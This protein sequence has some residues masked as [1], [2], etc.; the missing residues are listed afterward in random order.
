[1]TTEQA[2]NGFGRLSDTTSPYN[3]MAF[4]V[5]SI[6][7]GMA[8]NTLV[9]VKAV[10]ATATGFEVDVQPMVAQ[11]DGAGNAVAHGTIHGLPVW[12][13]QGGVSAVLVEPVAGDIG[14]AVFASTDISGVKRSGKATTPGSARRFD[15]SD[16]IYLGG[17]LNPVPT[18]FL[19]MDAT[20]ITITSTLPVAINAQDV[21][22]TATGSVGI[23]APDGAT[24]T[25][26]LDVTG[27]I[28]TG[29]GSTFNGKAFD[30]HTHSGV[31]TGSGN[32]GAPV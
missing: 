25:G 7:A 20:G 23:T 11:V 29:A 6:M 4:V 16:G 5:R 27:K 31:T 30:T 18:Q 21:T 32:T 24:I 12:R 22:V 26:D 14:L 19:R 2:F 28:T 15:W 17:L 3:Q 9:Q 10:R 8:T 1:M 13:V